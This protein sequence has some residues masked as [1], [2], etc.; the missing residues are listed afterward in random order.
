MTHAEQARLLYALLDAAE[1]ENRL[2]DPGVAERWL[3]L[4]ARFENAH[5]ER[6]YS[7]LEALFDELDRSGALVGTWIQA[8][9]LGAKTRRD[10]ESPF[11]R[12]AREA[13]RRR[14]AA[15]PN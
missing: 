8:R 3:A 13:G 10:T 2:V 9:W 4:K 12:T 14:P 15:G 5:S 1:D 7:A 6:H 11:P